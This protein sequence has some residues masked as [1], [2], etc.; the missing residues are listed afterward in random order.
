MHA[1]HAPG[2]AGYSSRSCGLRS[3]ADIAPGAGRLQRLP[4]EATTTHPP[5][6]QRVKEPPCEVRRSRIQGRGVF[7]TR[8]IRP[9]QRIV[10]YSGERISNEEADRR[11]DEER[12]RRHHTFLFTL[13]EDTVVDGARRGNVAKYINHS[14]DP[15]CVAVIEDDRIWIEARKNIQ[16]GVELTYDYQYERTGDADEELERFYKCEC[17]SRKCRGT[18][19]KPPRRRSRKRTR[20]TERRRAA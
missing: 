7:A 6:T 5:L 16:P 12:M 14:C 17:G 10:E 4:A 19:L 3:A 20:Q 2:S 13:D 8:R 15:N 1:T 18:I 9:G 11:Y